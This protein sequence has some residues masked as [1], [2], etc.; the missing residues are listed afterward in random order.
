M[1][2]SVLQSGTRVTV[3]IDC[4]DSNQAEKIAAELST[5]VNS[6]KFNPLKEEKPREVKPDRMQERYDASRESSRK[7][8]KAS[9]E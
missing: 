9:K 4:G 3:V 1:S 6:G 2:I 8:K 5:D 7:E